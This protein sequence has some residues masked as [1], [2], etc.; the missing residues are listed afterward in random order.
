VDPRD[1][2][3]PNG[4]KDA[5]EF[6]QFGARLKNGLPGGTQPLFQGSSVTGSSFK[7]GKPFDVGRQSDF[8]IALVGRALFD[9][10]RAL[11]IKAKDGTRI[12][13]L[14]PQDLENPGLLGLRD[15]LGALAGRPVNFMLFDS[16]GAALKR[17][18]VWVP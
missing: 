13:P 1:K 14:S 3:I 11:G 16:I 6:H 9:K 15:Q 17:P 18:S 12:G 7:T 4:F 10:A 2:S 5:E 8:D